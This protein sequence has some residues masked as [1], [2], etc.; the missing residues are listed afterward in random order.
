MEKLNFLLLLPDQHRGDWLP[1]DKRVFE[2]YRMESLPLRMPHVRKLMEAGTVFTRAV[3]PS[4][5][6][7]PAR[8]C[9]AAGLSYNACGVA[10]NGDNYPLSQKTFYNVLKEHGYS[11]G[12]V[13]KFDLNKA[14][15]WWGLDGWRDELS[16]LGFTHAVDNAG[17]MDAVL[18]GADE[19][20]DPYMT[21]L[22]EQGL[23][24]MHAQD[25]MF[26]KGE[27]HP[28]PL[29]DDAYCDNWLSAHGMEMLRDFPRE[30][31]WFMQVNFTGPHNPWDVTVGMREGWKNADL[32][33]PNRPTDDRD[34]Q[35]DIRRNYAA[36]LENIDRNIGLLFEEIKQR[37]EW[38]RTVIIYASD[39]GEM[40]GDYGKYGKSLPD[41]ASVHIPLIFSGPGVRKGVYSDALV[42]LQDVGA[43]VLDLAGL[44]MPEAK[45]AISMAPVLRGDTDTHRQ[46]QRSA[47]K[48]E[49]SAWSMICDGTYKYIVEQG[50][51]LRLYHLPSDPWEHSNLA[52]EQ[53]DARLLKLLS[54]LEESEE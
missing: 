41:R 12:G 4:P 51:P 6:C 52:A 53:E 25:M 50:K 35:I 43:T 3:T 13:G 48:T 8:A 2:A 22:H 11:V 34:R 23:A 17:K 39:H 26:R 32:P 31:P 37:G 21:Y 42:E 45:E 46:F 54:I 14:T 15:P 9:L 24:H 29:P 44:T 16:S 19:P 18:F 20:Q 47:L 38:D 33:E 28:T 49:G 10:D 7:A 30:H 36:M 27:T 1:Y 40:M 5:L